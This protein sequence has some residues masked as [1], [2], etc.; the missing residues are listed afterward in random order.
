[1]HTLQLSG[2]PWPVGTGQHNW[3]PSGLAGSGVWVWLLHRGRVCKSRGP[4][5]RGRGLSASVPWN[6]LDDHCGHFGFPGKQRR[7]DRAPWGLRGR[8]GDSHEYG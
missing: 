2:E 7:G 1:M 4:G 6:P 5:G 3:A 8:F